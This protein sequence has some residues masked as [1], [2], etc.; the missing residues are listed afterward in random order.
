MPGT[1]GEEGVATPLTEW[2]LNPVDWKKK[3]SAKHIFTH[4]EWHMTGYV[5]QVAG[6]CPDFIWV[7]R[8]ELEQLAVPSAFARFLEEARELL[9]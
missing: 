8:R 9:A 5:A 2:G 3:L 4:V 6:D 1:L 7:D